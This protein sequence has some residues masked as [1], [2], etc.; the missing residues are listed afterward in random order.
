MVLSVRD[1]LRSGVTVSLDD[2]GA[3][4]VSV[5]VSVWVLDEVLLVDCDGDCVGV[6]EGVFVSSYVSENVSVGSAVNV[7]LRVVLGDLDSVGVVVGETVLDIEISLVKVRV[8]VDVA[9][10]LTVSVGNFVRVRDS[11]GSSVWEGVDDAVIERSCEELDDSDSVSVGEIVRVVDTTSV[12]EL[13]IDAV[14][15]WVRDSDSSD[16]SVRLCDFPAVKVTVGVIVADFV[17]VRLCVPLGEAVGVGDRVKVV[18]YDSVAVVL[19]TDVKD[20]LRLEVP[21]TESLRV[22]DGDGVTDSD[23]SL[24][25][26]GVGVSDE[27]GVRVTVG[28]LVYVR[29]LETSSVRDGV[30]V[31]DPVRCCEIDREADSLRVGLRDSD[32]EGNIVGV[33]LGDDV[34]SS[35]SESDRLIDTV[36]VRDWSCVGLAEID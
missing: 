36:I 19:C 22:M 12:G 8:L 13:V 1:S 15:V 26:L 11:V 16:V 29:L 23:T 3:V 5:G 28:S 27:D 17:R 35:S 4:A 7:E 18:S 25:G 34:L 31:T 2:F 9:V 6:S 24:V 30:V 10:V 32:S 33:S 21:E 20:T 14:V